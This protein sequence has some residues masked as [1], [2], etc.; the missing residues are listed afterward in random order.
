M[1]KTMYE[2]VDWPDIQEFMD[3]PKW[4]DVGFD[5]NKNIWSVPEDFFEYNNTEIK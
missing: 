1:E 5:P 3:N 4:E 2:K